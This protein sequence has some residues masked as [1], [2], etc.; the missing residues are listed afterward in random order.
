MKR[1][2]AITGAALVLLLTEVAQGQSPEE[3][4]RWRMTTIAPETSAFYQLFAPP[5]VE[6][7]KQLTDGRIEI[8]PYPAGVIAPSFSAHDAVVDGTADAAQAPPIHLVSR[9]P[10]NAI[11]GGAMPGGMGPDALM[12]WMYQGGGKELLAEQRREILGLHSIP[13]G[14]GGSELLGHCHKPIRTADDL[15]GVKFRTIGAFAEILE[16]FFGAAPTVVP[17]SEVYTMLE[18]HAI[19]CAEWSGPAENTIAG[20]QETAKYIMY[21]GPQTNAFLME[22]TVKK[23]TWDAL[24]ADLQ[25]KVEAAAMLASFETL[26]AFDA[27]DIEAWE[28]LKQGDNE[29]VRLSDDLIAAFRDAGR[30]WA[31]EKA[32]EQAAN[33]NPWMEEAAKSYFSFYDNWLENADFRAIDIRYEQASGRE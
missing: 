7:V 9:D 10:V 27:R 21:P 2:M 22:F 13:A 32:K 25:Q 19:D 29:I 18:R 31:F 4:I 8:T 20:L 12:H 15:K 6:H 24:P 26:L 23:E 1:G 11:L 28:K 3:P 16:A 33:G 14:M 17:G 5:L 30:Q